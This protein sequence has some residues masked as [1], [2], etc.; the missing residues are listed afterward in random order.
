MNLMS[1]ILMATASIAVLSACGGG[2][3]DTAQAIGTSDPQLRFANV[4]PFAPALTLAR[5]GGNRTEATNV[6]N[7]FLSD[8][9][10]VD[11]GSADYRV[12]GQVNT[13]NPPNP[14]FAFSQTIN[15]D[16]KRGHKYTIL[17][18]AD[19]SVPLPSSGST[20]RQNTLVLVDDPTNPSLVDDQSYVRAVNGSFSAKNIDL[21]LIGL[22]E[23]ID[24]RTPDLPSIAF[25][26]SSP[27]SGLDAI[28][29]R[30]GD[31]Q[32]VATTAG[33]KNILYRGR[34]TI[35]DKRDVLFVTFPYI[36]FLPTEN[37]SGSGIAIAAKLQ[38]D[39]GRGGRIPSL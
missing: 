38:G 24:A 30:G 39:G 35:P 34:F 36:A 32:V 21:Y 12:S 2:S 19:D 20:A 31:Y 29:R 5:N 7:I 13:G 27:A 25:K 22:T 8:Y 28:G 37:P 23:T 11:T 3:S 16:A 17:T 18:L 4:S 1:K 26:Q 15:F 9:F 33:T 14:E 10:T 6:S